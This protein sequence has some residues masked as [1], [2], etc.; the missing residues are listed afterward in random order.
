MTSVGVGAVGV[1]VVPRLLV[2]ADGERAALGE[3]VAAL[4]AGVGG[5]ALVVGEA[6]S[7]K[8]SL[9]AAVLEGLGDDVELVWVTGDELGEGFPLLPLVEAAAERG[10]GDIER[11]LRGGLDDGGGVADSVV[12]ASERLTAWVED[13]SAGSP[14]ML[15][16]DDLHWADDASLRLW[17]RLARSAGQMPLLVVGAMRQGYGRDELTVLRRRVGESQA[18][19]RGVVVELGALAPAAVAE[20][21]AGLVGGRPGERLVGLVG[22]AG[23]NPCMSPSWW[24]AACSRGK[25]LSGAGG[26]VEAVRGYEAG[27]LVEVIGGRF[28]LVAA[29]VR[30]V[31]QVAALLGVEFS[32]ADLGVAA[33]RPVGELAGMLAQAQAAGVVVP[34]GRGMAFRHPCIREV[35]CAR[36]PA[37]VRGVWHVELGRVLA[38]RGAAAVVVARQLTAAVECGAELPGAGWLAGWLVAEGPVLASQAD[39]GCDPVVPAGA[40]AGGGGGSAA[41]GTGGVAGLGAV[42][43]GQ[44]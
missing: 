31:L 33:G 26:R 2:G 4:E 41:G 21:A 10:R 5:A 12:A 20:L 35:L 37:G 22:A 16:F 13:L 27:S 25:A 7:G 1:G 19:G 40:G 30:E 11:L 29:P 3:L 6:G 14:V 24:C 28:D 15:V 38:E 43:G 8:S 39:R 23:G 32:V 44:V 36:V 18:A 42:R 9:M 17:Y 34:R